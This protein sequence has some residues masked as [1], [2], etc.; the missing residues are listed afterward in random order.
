MAGDTEFF[1]LFEEELSGWRPSPLVQDRVKRHTVE[2]IIDVR[3][4]Q[5]LGA[6]VPQMV[7]NVMV[8]LRRLDRPIAEQV[9]AVAKISC[10]SCPARAV[11]REPQVVE[12]LEK[13]PTFFLFFEKKG[14]IRHSSSS[15]FPG[16]RPGQSSTAVAEQNV[17][18]PVPRRGGPRGG[19]QGFSLD[20]G[21][22]ATFPVPLRDA[23]EGFFALFLHPIKVRRSTGR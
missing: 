6:L 10:S 15:S 1:S 17:D 2:H 22:A 18:T 11:L 23:G 9:I 14:E 19:L 12:Q 7:D 13:V 5:I 8:A 20:Q 21:S 3:Y 4:V 16:L